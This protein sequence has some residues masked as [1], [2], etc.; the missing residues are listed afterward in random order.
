MTTK[1]APS[2][3][4]ITGVDVVDTII[5]SYLHYG[6]T[7]YFMTK[8]M[9]MLCTPSAF[10]LLNIKTIVEDFVGPMEELHEMV[11]NQTTEFFTLEQMVRRFVEYNKRFYNET[12]WYGE[13]EVDGGACQFLMDSKIFQSDVSDD[14]SGPSPNFGPC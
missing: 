3:D 10:K 7:E 14:C 8:Y 6:I 13:Q 2:M 1:V 4:A 9:K 11:Y 12:C 5:K